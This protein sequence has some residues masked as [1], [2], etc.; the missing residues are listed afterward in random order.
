MIHP[1][2]S[3]REG[4]RRVLVTAPQTEA[5]V[6]A[7]PPVQ[8]REIFRR[9]WPYSRGYRVWIALGLVVVGLIELADL[10]SIWMFKLVIDEV[11]VPRDFGP[12]VW[13]ALAYVGLTLYEGLLKFL[14]RY[15]GAW[16]SGRFVLN[17]RTEV[18]RHVQGLSL[19]FLDRRRTG[20][21]MARL[22]GDVGAIETFVISGVNEFASYIFMLIFFIGALFYLNWQLALV[23]ITVVPAFWL[24]A[25]YFSRLM[26]LASRERRRRSGS[27]SV[28]AEEG[29]SN[30]AV[31]QAYNREDHQA[32]RFYREGHGNYEASLTVARIRGV[33]GPLVNLIE[34]T[35]ALLVIAFGTYQLTEGNISLGGLIVFFTLMTSLYGPV[36]GLGGLVSSLF[37]A[38]AAAERIIEVMDEEPEVKSRPGAVELAQPRGSVRFEDV[39]FRYQG[40]LHD[41][42]SKVSFALE[43]GQTV[44][45][46]GRSGA[47]KSTIAKLLLRFYDPDAGRVLYDGHDLRDV[48][49]TSLREGIAVVLQEALVFQGTVR[50][51]IAFGHPGATDEQIVAA[52]EAAAA[53]E[54]IAALPDGY[55]TKIGEKGRKLSGG[56]RQRI[57][58]ARAFVRDAPVL[59][60]DEP[61]TGLD[62]ESGEQILEP[63]RRLMEGRS[64]IIIS[65][66]LMTVREADEILFLEDGR[67]RERGTHDE[68]LA[69]GGGYARLYTM[70]ESQEQEEAELLA[71]P[72]EPA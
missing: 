61:T 25:A 22:T 44:A 45:L 2:R 49:L 37:S 32:R 9:F 64:T 28:I 29:L 39:T 15:L 30:A 40:T 69:A 59:I 21:L 26:K 54:F 14:D 33:Y 34:L 31:I 60:L 42:L 46:V 36:R 24:V 13:I 6:E 7:S 3:A 50:E 68:L 67:V 56:Q 8:V 62:A 72:P 17:L 23:A 43:P 19:D 27:I 57:A 63:L 66:N 4:L 47:G 16:T 20:D 71:M 48:E 55:E 10:A 11:F 65:H 1:I 12:F 52:A 70:H 51:N 5:L 38:A 35:G 41:A 53:R 58:V 18:F